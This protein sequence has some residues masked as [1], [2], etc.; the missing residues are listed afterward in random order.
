MDISIV[1]PF[2]NVEQYIERCV[3]ALLSQRFPKDS[4]EII[5]VDNN[6]T[7]GSAEIVRRYSQ[8]KL[9]CE[10]KIG[11]YAARNRGVAESRGE[12]IA[13]TDSDCSPAPDWLQKIGQ[14]L[15]SPRVCIVQGRQC[16]ASKS[17]GLSVL[18]DYE[19]EKAAYIF[20]ARRVETYYSHANSMAVRRS[21]FD[22]VGPFLEMKRG[23]DTVFMRRVIEAYSNDAALYSPDMCVQ[24]LEVSSIWNMFQK[25]N[26]YGKSSRR[27]ARIVKCRQLNIRERLEV[28]RTTIERAAADGPWKL[29]NNPISV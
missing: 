3:L 18:N 20:S 10:S 28:L 15:A 1:V 16:A 12:I 29:G 11:A 25:M 6:S 8:I 23:A 2:H 17:L 22:R 26:I 7:D 5:M 24:H 13:F 9:L 19:A 14:A 27:Y 21:V 4:F